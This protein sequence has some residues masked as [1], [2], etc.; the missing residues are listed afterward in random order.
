MLG[1]LVVGL[2]LGWL[3]DWYGIGP[4][5]SVE[6]CGGMVVVWLCGHLA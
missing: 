1:R 6:K 3:V 2:L 5:L 4:S